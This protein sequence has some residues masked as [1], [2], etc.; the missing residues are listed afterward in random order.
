MLVPD[1][2][3]NGEI[4]C[5]YLAVLY[6]KRFDCHGAFE[7]NGMFNVPEFSQVGQICDPRRPQNSHEIRADY[8]VPLNL[9]AIARLDR[10]LSEQEDTKLIHAFQGAAKFYLQALQM[11]SNTIP[12]LP[13]F[14]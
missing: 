13:T 9:A 11:Q 2:S 5:S 7:Q 1:Y 3:I 12:K 10:L 4:L 14:I 6:G 8:G